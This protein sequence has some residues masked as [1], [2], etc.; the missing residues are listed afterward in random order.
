ML[1]VRAITKAMA[2]QE[3]LTYQGRY[4]QRSLGRGSIINIASVMS[5]IGARGKLPY[6][7]SKHA[8]MGITKTAGKSRNMPL[9][10]FRCIVLSKSVALDNTMHHIRV[11]AICPAW[12]DTPMMAADFDKQHELKN[13]IQAVSPVQRMAV[14]DEV[15]DLIVFLSSASAS[16]INGQGIVVDAGVTLTMNRM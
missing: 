15:G 12:V 4:G 10:L 1:C 5:S 2:L 3:P 11:N 9:L 13:I 7:A 8:I 6:A 16:Y 14:P